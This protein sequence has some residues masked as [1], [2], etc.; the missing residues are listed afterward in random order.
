MHIYHD[1]ALAYK[2]W[3]INSTSQSLQD[4]YLCVQCNVE[5]TFIQAEE[6]VSWWQA[7]LMHRTNTNSYSSKKSVLLYTDGDTFQQHT[8]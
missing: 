2:K 1:I 3:C 6:N 8:P 5:H 7:W 4:M